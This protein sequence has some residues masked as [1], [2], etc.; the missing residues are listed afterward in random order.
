MVTFDPPSKTISVSGS[1]VFYNGDHTTGTYTPGVYSVEIRG[2]GDNNY[3][4][5][6][7]ETITVTIVDPCD[8][9]FT[10][11]NDII[12]QGTIV[13]PNPI[14][15]QILD[16]IDSHTLTASAATVN[17]LE[18][19]VSCPEIKFEVTNLDFTT[20]LDSIFAWSF[21]SQTLQ[22]QSDDMAEL[23][24]LTRDLRISAFYQGGSAIT[25]TSS[26][27]LDITV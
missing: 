10:G 25:Y 23:A 24:T 5:G 22:I 12:I 6:T 17:E 3:D 18:T 21:A 2:W 11:T 4:S 27:Y 26:G 1:D 14:L 16:P 13:S 9:N 19:T 15:Y 8:P 7:F 20:T